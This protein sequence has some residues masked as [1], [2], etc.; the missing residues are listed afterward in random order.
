MVELLRL[1]EEIGCD[2]VTDGELRR[3][4][5]YSFVAEK[6]DGVRLMT[7]AEMLDVVEDKAGF[8]RMLQTLDVPAY[9]ISN[10]GLR[11]ARSRR[12]AAGGR[13]TPFRQAAH[14]PADQDHAARPLPADPRNVRPGADARHLPD[15][16]GLAEDVVALLRDE[17]AELA[18]RGRLRAVR[19]AGA[20]RAG[21]APGR[22]GP[23]CVRR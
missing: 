18:A 2:I 10:S 19:R 4:N 22:H 6:L 16:R 21:F 7:L 23:S 8:E 3:D 17:L 1:Q 9:S 12:A 13:R 20:D 14:R 15:E 11:R 5:F